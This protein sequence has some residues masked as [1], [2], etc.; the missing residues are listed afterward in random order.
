[1]NTPTH[2][3]VNGA[4]SP[5]PERTSSRALATV[6]LAAGVSALV[7]GAD[8]WM[9]PWAERHVLAAWIALWAIAVAAIVVL[10][11]A[12]RAL[13]RQTMVGLDAWS[14]RV[15]QRRADRRLWAMAQTDARLMSDLQAAMDR[16]QDGPAKDVLTL[17]QRRAQ[18]IVRNRLHYI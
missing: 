6:L 18:R 11:G 2:T 8:Q 17:S 9:E 5:R 3:A 1:M 13:A 7:V 10:R 14:A 12:T 16:D 4:L 15:A